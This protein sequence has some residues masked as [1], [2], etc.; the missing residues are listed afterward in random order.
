MN[1]IE[2]RP[3]ISSE[4]SRRVWP[5]RRVRGKRAVGHQQVQAAGGLDNRLRFAVAALVIDGR[6]RRLVNNSHEF[7]APTVSQP[8]K[9]A[10]PFDFLVG[11]TSYFMV[12]PKFGRTTEWRR[13]GGGGVFHGGWFC[14][15]RLEV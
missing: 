14:G 7:H 8:R 15:V 2:K 10:A 5:R 1:A 9:F 13:R 3:V 4:N 11:G 12:R 6:A